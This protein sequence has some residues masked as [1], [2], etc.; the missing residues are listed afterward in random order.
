MIVRDSVD[1]HRTSGTE[2]HRRDVKFPYAEINIHKPPC[3]AT[4]LV[5]SQTSVSN[6]VQQGNADTFLV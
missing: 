2:K 1:V 4:Q 6:V 5:A 3:F